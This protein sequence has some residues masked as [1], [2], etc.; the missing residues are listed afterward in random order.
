[1]KKRRRKMFYDH[2]IAKARQEQLLRDAEGI[3]D[4]E[5]VPAQTKQPLKGQI[6]ARLAALMGI[7][8]QEAGPMTGPSELEREQAI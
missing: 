7:Q 5:H 4:P 2:R 3:Q 8:I 6:F 1:M